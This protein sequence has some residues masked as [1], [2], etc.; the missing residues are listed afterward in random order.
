MSEIM[1][2]NAKLALIRAACGLVDA[3][4]AGDETEAAI[5]HLMRAARHLDRCKSQNRK[6]YEAGLEKLYDGGVRDE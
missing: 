3:V 4:N 1:V 5:N 6:M 2:T